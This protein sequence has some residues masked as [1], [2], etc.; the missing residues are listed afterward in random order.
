MP[1]LYEQLHDPFHRDKEC[2]PFNFPL[3]EEGWINNLDHTIYLSKRL[4]KLEESQYNNYVVEVNI[5]LDESETYLLHALEHDLYSRDME[6]MEFAVHGMNLPSGLRRPFSS[7]RDAAFL[8]NYGVLRSFTACPRTLD[9]LVEYIPASGYVVESVNFEGHYDSKYFVHN[10]RAS[11]IP[12]RTRRMGYIGLF[13]MID[14]IIPKRHR[15]RIG[16]IDG[17]NSQSYHLF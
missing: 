12:S 13:N 15:E 16:Y 14:G 11:L 3:S 8:I 17:S 9:R 2:I 10:V 1:A 6:W 5:Q 7:V 4:H